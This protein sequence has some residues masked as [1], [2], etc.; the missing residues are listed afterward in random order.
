MPKLGGLGAKLSEKSLNCVSPEKIEKFKGLK[1][2][3]FQHV[4]VLAFKLTFNRFI[5]SRRKKLPKFGRLLG[6]KP[7]ETAFNCLSPKINGQLRSAIL[8][9]SFTQT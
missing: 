5:E 1:V 2:K 4:N 8:L 9:L 3:T 6:A 7:C